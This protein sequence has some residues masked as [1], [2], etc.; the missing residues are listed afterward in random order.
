MNA[1]ESK[2]TLTMAPFLIGN[3]LV[4]HSGLIT[5]AFAGADL[6]F[7]YRFAFF[8]YSTADSTMTQIYREVSSAAWYVTQHRLPEE[9]GQRKCDY[10]SCTEST[11][12]IICS[13]HQKHWAWKNNVIPFKMLRSGYRW[14]LWVSG[15]G[16]SAFRWSICLKSATPIWSSL[17]TARNRD[18]QTNSKDRMASL[19]ILNNPSEECLSLFITLNLYL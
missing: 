3:K 4:S 15:M 6:H 9:W 11:V 13:I 18:P 2:Q 16:T 7:G 8:A 14:P 12:L 5:L 17:P 1:R 19:I 10:T